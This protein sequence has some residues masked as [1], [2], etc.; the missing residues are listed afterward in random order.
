MGGIFFVCRRRLHSAPSMNLTHGLFGDYGGVPLVPSVFWTSLT[1]L[2]PL[3]VLLLFVRPRPGVAL[4][5][6]IIVTDVIHNTWLNQY[7]G[8]RP[9][10]EYAAQVA[11]LVFVLATA[12]TAWRL[13]PAPACG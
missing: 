8:V 1:F 12:K 3:A 7:L 2:D 9:G 4:T 13:R 5:V 6:A 11:F 10:V